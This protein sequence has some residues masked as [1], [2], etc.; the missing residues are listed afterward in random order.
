MK[1]HYPLSDWQQEGL[2]KQSYVDVGEIVLLDKSK[3][4]FHY[5]GEL[6]LNDTRSLIE[7]IK[8]RYNL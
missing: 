4:I 8:Q 3:M 5:V 6:S 1:N 7:F 2:K